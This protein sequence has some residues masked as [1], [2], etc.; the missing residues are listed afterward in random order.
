[1]PTLICSGVNRPDLFDLLAQERVAGMVNAT[2][3]CQPSLWQACLRHSDISLCLDSGAFQGKMELATY[4]AIVEQIGR[5]FTWVANLDVIGDQRRSNEHY[6]EL[7]CRLPCELREKLLWVY[8]GGA[9]DELAEVAQER[10]FV[11]IGGIVRLLV[12]QGPEAVLAYLLML[13]EVLLRTDA[14][15]H[16]FGLGSPYLLRRLCGMPWFRSFDTS[17]WLLAYKAEAVLLENGARHNARQLGLRLT[18]RECA[19]NNIRQLQ[20]WADPSSHDPLMLSIWEETP[21]FTL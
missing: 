2:E 19:C 12:E 9:V 8:Q 13:G 17:K 14:Q 16:I 18:S 11:G 3:A 10:K 1:M 7:R 15:A 4:L 20:A 21:P 5:R 6:Q